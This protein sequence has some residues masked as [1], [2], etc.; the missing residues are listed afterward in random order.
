MTILRYTAAIAL[1][2]VFLQYLSHVHLPNDG[3]FLSL[4]PLEKEESIVLYQLVERSVCRR[5][6]FT[7]Y[8]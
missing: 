7:K 6:A 8:L 2:Y 1:M 5:S 3:L 4:L